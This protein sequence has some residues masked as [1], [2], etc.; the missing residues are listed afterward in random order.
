MEG[1][2]D[3]FRNEDL[4]GVDFI[5]HKRDSS[6][7]V[8]SITFCPRLLIFHLKNS[9]TIRGKESE[10]VGGGVLWSQFLR[11]EDSFTENTEPTYDNIPILC[12]VKGI[13][14]SY[15]TD[16]SYTGCPRSETSP[17]IIGARTRDGVQPLNP[18]YFIPRYVKVGHDKL[19]S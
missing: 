5:I 7:Y 18:E 10:D 2:V 1:L 15:V 17:V 11:T 19:S 14:H 12:S 13:G 3:K 16:K 4:S 9:F 8:S 6:N